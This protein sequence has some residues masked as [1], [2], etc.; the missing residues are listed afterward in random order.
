MSD[1]Y[2]V[3]SRRFLMALMAIGVLLC[4]CRPAPGSLPT[5]VRPRSEPSAAPSSGVNAG[6]KGNG[7]GGRK[8]RTF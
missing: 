4:A 5:P 8:L 6:R 3:R 1:Q 2:T 7:V